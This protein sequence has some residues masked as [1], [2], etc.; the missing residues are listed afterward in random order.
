MVYGFIFIQYIGQMAPQ[1][2]GGG[3]RALAGNTY[4]HPDPDK[5]APRVP[6]GGLRS[7]NCEAH[8]GIRG[9]FFCLGTA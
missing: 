2:V 7:G 6:V 9:A 3:V 4:A 1:E 8:A 5:K